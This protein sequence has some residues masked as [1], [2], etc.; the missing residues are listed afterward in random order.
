MLLNNPIDFYKKCMDV[1]MI[2]SLN[3]IYLTYIFCNIR[4][5]PLITI[6]ND[7][8]FITFCSILTFTNYRLAR[9]YLKIKEKI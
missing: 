2:T 7:K 4:K 8:Y 5:K 6:V 3:S 1:I 9:I